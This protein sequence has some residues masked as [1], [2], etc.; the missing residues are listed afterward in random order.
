M[1]DIRAI[2]FDFDGVLANSEPLH[3]RS[4]QAVLGELGI[5]LDRDEYYA[6]Y[7]GFDDVTAFTV[8]SERR[9]QRWSD[10]QIAAILERKT[11][12]FDDIVASTASSDVLYPEAVS[13]VR[14]LAE[15]M[16][17]GIASGA[18][19]HEI[20]AILRR[21]DLEDCFR[22]I[23]AAGE[24]PR[25]SRRRTRIGGRRS[26][27]ACRPAQCVAIEDSRWGIES[28][29][30]AGLRCVGI[31]QTY[32]ASRA[33]GR[34]RHHRFARRVHSRSVDPALARRRGTSARRTAAWHV[35]RSTW[36][37]ARYNRGSE[38]RVP[39]PIAQRPGRR[40]SGERHERAGRGARRRRRWRSP[41]SNIPR[42]TPTATWKRWSAW[43][44]KRPG[45]W[46]GPACAARTPS[47]CSTSISTTSSAS[48]A[49]AS[50]TTIRATASSTRCSIA[51]PAFPSRSPSSTSRSRA[52]PAST[53]RA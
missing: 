9:G 19:R 31:T 16:P 18:L 36:H 27:T 4:Y 35:A 52:A 50:T 12:I 1:A 53:S 44:T 30:G 48:P 34:R 20:A 51:A 49:T 33:S 45:A 46:H 39:S 7:L 47:P 32:P 43:A 15:T 11:V 17:L 25:A 3:L 42:S 2:V 40:R 41:A 38:I 13:C 26:C 23:V 8:I 21:A 37:V 10:A 29:K 28:A 6:H 5:A 22:F 14:R 24:T